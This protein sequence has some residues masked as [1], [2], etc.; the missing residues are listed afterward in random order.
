[1]PEMARQNTQ[2]SQVGLLPVVT[3]EPRGGDRLQRSKLA[4]KV[5]AK[6]QLLSSLLR[7]KAKKG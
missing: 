3:V 1:M 5:G 4:L 6:E 7:V 2:R